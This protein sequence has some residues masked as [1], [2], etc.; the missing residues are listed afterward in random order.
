MYFILMA[1][2]HWCRQ[3]SD[4][5]ARDPLDFQQIFFFQFALELRN[6]LQRIFVV[7][8]TNILQPVTAD[9]VV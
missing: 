7:I 3:L 4:T 2:S 9:A 6:V 1:R 8:S 5:G